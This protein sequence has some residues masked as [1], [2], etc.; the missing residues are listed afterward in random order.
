MFCRTKDGKGVYTYQMQVIQYMF[1]RDDSVPIRF[2]TAKVGNILRPFIYFVRPK[3]SLSLNDFLHN[4]PI[5]SQIQDNFNMQQ[6][7]QN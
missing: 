2:G 7:N 4:N 5:L 6:R 3:N 1:E